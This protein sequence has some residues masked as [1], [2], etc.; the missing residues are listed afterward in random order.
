MMYLPV[1]TERSNVT[2]SSSSSLTSAATESRRPRQCSKA[3]LA[4]HVELLLLLALHIGLAEG[5]KD[6]V[7]PSRANLCLDHL[8]R[9][10]DAAQQPA[11]SPARLADL[12]LLLQ[13]VLLHRGNQ[14]SHPLLVFTL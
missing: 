13:D 14:Y 2:G 8:G 4:I 7:Q 10:R 5:A 9:Q 11:K 6:V 1:S 12:L 3:W